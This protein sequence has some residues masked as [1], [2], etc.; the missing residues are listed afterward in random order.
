MATYLQDIRQGDDYVIQFDY[1][2]DNDI[3]GFEFWLTIK[4]SF[5]DIDASAILQYSTTAGDDP[6]DDPTH[7]TAVMRVP[8]SITKEA[9]TGSYYYDVQ[10]RSPTGQVAT[11]VPPVEDYKDK[12]MIAPEVTRASL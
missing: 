5:D 3:T 12:I 6:S 7:G 10:V 2:T 9:I 8:A 11:I 1:G 4:E